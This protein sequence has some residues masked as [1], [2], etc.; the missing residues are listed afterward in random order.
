MSDHRYRDISYSCF[1]AERQGRSRH[2]YDFR[3]GTWPT[4]SSLDASFRACYTDLNNVE[5]GSTVSH[6]IAGET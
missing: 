5:Y 3:T 2:L 1:D 6:K 4:S